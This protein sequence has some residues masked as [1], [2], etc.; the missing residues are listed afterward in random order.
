MLGERV[1]SRFK[2][3]ISKRRKGR[4]II[5]VIRWPLFFGGDI[6]SVALEKRGISLRFKGV[7]IAKRYKLLGNIKSSFVLRNVVDAVGVE[8]TVSLYNSN[9]NFFSLGIHDYERKKF[10]YRS[11][12]LYYIR[13]KSNRASLVR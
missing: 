5:S 12:K 7:C 1:D 11:S 3:I 6:I 2:A 8:F 4:F 9:V 13:M 10:R